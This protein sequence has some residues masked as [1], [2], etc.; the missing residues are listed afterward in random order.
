[1][2]RIIIAAIVLLAGYA[3]RAQHQEISEKPNMYK[4]KAEQSID[5]TSLLAAFKK[6]HVNGHFRYFFMATNNQNGLTDYYANAVG[7][8]LRFE[9]A[10]FHGFQFA[11][12][13]FYT[14]NIGS[15]DLGKPDSITGQTNRYEIALFDVEN[16]YNK[17][18]IDRLEELYIK[19]N[20]KS[21]SV[22]FGRQLLNTPFINLQDGRMR[23]T[24]VE[25][26]WFEWNE[27]KKIRLEGGWLYGVSP[28]AV[29]NGILPGDR[30]ASIPEASMR[31]ATNPYTPGNLESKG[32]LMLG[33]HCR[34]E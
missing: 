1:M 9:T 20:Y 8:G 10:K 31:T 7:G 18:D 6:G 16:A 2:K 4:G 19:Y 3:V 21:S 13:G 33:T 12:S 29:P 5:T 27:F 14:F 30:L 32:I 11:V 22:T 23:P 25:G 28:R 17:K 24:G 15:S 34:A 26:V